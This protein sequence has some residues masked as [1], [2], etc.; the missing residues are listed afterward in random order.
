M[1]FAGTG[2][3]IVNDVTNGQVGNIGIGLTFGM[4]VMVMIYVLSPISGAHLNPAVTVAFWITRSFDMRWSLGYICSQLLGAA[5]ASTL[6]HWLFPQHPTLGATLPH[7][8]AIQSFILE[9]LLAFILVFAIL[10]IAKKAT[11][12]RFA[13]AVVIGSIIALGAI[14]AGP[15]SGASMNPARSLAPAF[16]S[17]EIQSLWIY[18]LAPVLGAL[19]AVPVSNF[20]DAKEL[21]PPV[22]RYRFP[23]RKRL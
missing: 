14:F 21:T 6:L 4:V 3:I 18:L 8:S 9:I 10:M 13:P 11:E 17:G 7:G 16:L 5:A 12:K 15:I 23:S 1:V 2:A 22:L 20:L 19:I